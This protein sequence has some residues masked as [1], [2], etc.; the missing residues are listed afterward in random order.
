MSKK[1]KF[2][3]SL[4]RK[5]FQSHRLFCEQLKK[6]KKFNCKFLKSEKKFLCC[7]VLFHEFVQ[8]NICT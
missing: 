8:V 3:H 7:N 4:K 5:Y 1:K 2:T 6:N